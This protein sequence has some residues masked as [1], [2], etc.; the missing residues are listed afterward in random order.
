MPASVEAS[1]RWLRMATQ[2][3]RACGINVMAFGTARFAP[4]GSASF[5]G[6]AHH[7]K[8]QTGRFVN[9][10]HGSSTRT[11]RER[12]SLGWPH[13]A[14]APDLHP[15]A[16]PSRRL[17]RSNF[18]GGPRICQ[19]RYTDAFSVFIVLLTPLMSD[20]SVLFTGTFGAEIRLPL[21]SHTRMSR[22]SI[23]LRGPSVHYQLGC[24]R[25]TTCRPPST[26]PTTTP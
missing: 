26:C 24:R 1:T 8:P 12:H 2:G 14:R 20:P 16:K 13:I 4:Q 22:P 25:S 23:S 11:P 6:S 18:G 17:N 21:P 7:G 5:R 15:R 19:A 3:G 10:D 9:V